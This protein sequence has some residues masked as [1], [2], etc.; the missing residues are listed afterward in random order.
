MYAKTAI[1][2]NKKLFSEELL[3]LNGFVNKMTRTHLSADDMTRDFE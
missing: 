3:P 2:N 1:Y